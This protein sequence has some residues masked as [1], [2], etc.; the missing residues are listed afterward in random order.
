LKKNGFSI[1]FGYG[2]VWLAEGLRGVSAMGG[3]GGTRG[4]KTITILRRVRKTYQG[5][6]FIKGG[7]KKGRYV[8]EEGLRIQKG[9]R[10]RKGG[11]R[12]TTN[13]HSKPGGRGGGFFFSGTDL[14]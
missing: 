1:N 10:L 7:G 2:G 11:F 14:Q 12:V 8:G 9:G 4:S 3:K 6:D 5:I 13:P